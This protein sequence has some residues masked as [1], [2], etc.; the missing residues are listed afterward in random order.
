MIGVEVSEETTNRLHTLLA[1]V[2]DIDKKVLQP[3]LTRGLMAGKAMASKK[4]R[5]TYKIKK[6]DFDSKGKIN[7]NPISQ[8]GDELIGDFTF[9][10]AVIPLAKFQITPSTPKQGK[11][12]SA[13]VL[14]ASSLVPFSRENNVFVAQMKSGHVGIFERKDNRKIKELFA[15]AVPTMVGNEEVMKSVEERIN[16][17]VNKRI[18]HGIERLLKE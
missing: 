11:T 8:N 6:Q 12:P 14:K 13:A 15:P 18:D 1:G 4:A 2:E 10:G 17:I 3:A 5:E 7:Y 9:A 16:E